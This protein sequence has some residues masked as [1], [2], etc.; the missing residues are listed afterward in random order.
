MNPISEE[1]GQTARGVVDAMKGSPVLIALIVL[2]AFT[3]GG[4]AW[5][6][7][8]RA[9]YMNEERKMFSEERKLFLEICVQQRTDA[10]TPLP[11][12]NPLRQAG[13]E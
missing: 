1:V 6:I 11:K 4:V 5:S 3:M 10:I 12:P 2:Q 7:N 13:Q 9:N 8:Q